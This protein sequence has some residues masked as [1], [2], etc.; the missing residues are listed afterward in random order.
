[1]LRRRNTHGTFEDELV[2]SKPDRLQNVSYLNGPEENWVDER[3]HTHTN[4]PAQHAKAVSLCTH[5][6]GKDLRWQ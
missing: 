3:R 5:L 1:M 2:R 4:R 6:A